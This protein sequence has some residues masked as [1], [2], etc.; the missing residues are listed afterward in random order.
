VGAG[1]KEILNVYRRRKEE[2]FSINGSL[3]EKKQKCFI[4]KTKW[5]FRRK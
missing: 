1:N 3:E 4:L 2:R 5:K